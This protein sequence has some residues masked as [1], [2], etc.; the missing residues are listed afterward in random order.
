M[1]GLLSVTF[2]TDYRKYAHKAVV[3]PCS[4]DNNNNCQIST[5]TKPNNN[6]K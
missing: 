3:L 5:N 4:H 6:T 1:K 2:L